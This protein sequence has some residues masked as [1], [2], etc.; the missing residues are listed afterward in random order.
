[1]FIKTTLLYDIIT[2]KSVTEKG[3]FYEKRNETTKNT[4]SVT[5]KFRSKK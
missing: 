4:T 5:T 3:G 2:L 1:M